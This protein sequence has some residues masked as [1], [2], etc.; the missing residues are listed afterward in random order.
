MEKEEI[1][2]NK[3][4]KETLD[5]QNLIKL[6]QLRKDYANKYRTN[7][8]FPKEGW[9]QISKDLGIGKNGNACRKR[10]IDIIGKY[11]VSKQL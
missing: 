7:R 4:G 5:N 10:F 1:K 8:G 11:K 2:E 9:D 6:L 3:W